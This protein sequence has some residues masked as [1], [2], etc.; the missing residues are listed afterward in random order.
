MIR[1]FKSIT[2]ATML[3]VT[4]L[5]FTGCEGEFDD[6]FG[7]WSR[8][9]GNVNSGNEKPSGNI[10]VTSITLN[11]TTLEKK[12]GDVAVTLTATVKPDDATDKTV[13]WTS[14]DPAVASVSNG[15][16]SI[17]GEGTTIITAAAND[18]SGVKATCTV[19][20]KIPGLLAGKFSVSATKQ[21]RFSQ[22]TLQAKIAGYITTDPGHYT[23]TASSWEF[24]EHQWDYIGNAAGNNSFAVG[25]KVDLFGWVG[26]S[27]SYNSYGLCNNA[28]SVLGSDFANCYGNNDSES[29]KY[30]WGTVAITNGGNTP[31]IFGWR[32]LSATE[33][34]YLFK[35]RTASTVGGTDDGRYA[36]AK[37]NG[38]AGVILF[39]DSYTHPDGVTAPAS[40]NTTNAAYT[41]NTSDATAWGKMEAAG[42]VFLPAAGKRDGTNVN[43]VGNNGHYWSSTPT[44]NQK[45]LAGHLLFYS[46]GMSFPDNNNL[47]SNQAEFRLNGRSVRLVYDVK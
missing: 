19:T 7:E 23:Y 43:T 8:P 25:S 20:V 35:T 38:V 40:V 42:C 11:E 3:L 46:N 14:E 31:F 10:A 44:S 18:G 6:L 15:L 24:A 2:T 34:G 22:G 30:D 26:A 45:T 32:T 4:T 47:T 33:W 36:K 37:V 21:V 13:T 9:T 27:A 29:L 17:L 1:S 16:V 12:L 28:S 41:A 39:P 5:V